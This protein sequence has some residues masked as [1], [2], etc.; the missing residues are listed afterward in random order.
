MDFPLLPQTMA[1]PGRTVRRPAQ[2]LTTTASLRETA[3]VGIRGAHGDEK[4][5]DHEEERVQREQP[6]PP[7][8]SLYPT[9]MVLSP[10]RAEE[11]R[12]QRKQP[13]P[14]P[15]PFSPRPDGSAALARPTGGVPA[16]LATTTVDVGDAGRPVRATTPVDATTTTASALTSATNAATALATLTAGVVVGATD[17]A[18]AS[19]LAIADAFIT[20]FA[21]RGDTNATDADINATA[22]VDANAVFNATTTASDAVVACVDGFTVDTVFAFTIS[23]IV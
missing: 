11:E 14:L 16:A 23:T 6:E 20:A 5:R 15:Q 21:S 22:V 7:L 8:Q 1:M 17:A 13:E 4:T 19:N 10:L 12:T 9:P 3:S 18:N 2:P